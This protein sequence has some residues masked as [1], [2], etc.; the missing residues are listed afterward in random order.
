MIHLITWLPLPYQR[1]LCQTL[2]DYYEGAFRAWFAARE[3]EDFPFRPVQQAE[4]TEYYLSEVGYQKLFRELRADREAV[5]ILGGWSSP[6]ANKTLLITTL[7]GIPVFIWA[8]HPH[9]RQRTRIADQLR[10]SYLRLLSRVVS[11]FLACGD[12]TVRHLVSLGIARKKI[13]GFSYWVKIP[14]EWSVPKRCSDQ[15][16]HARP[17]RLVAV[18]RHILVKQFGVAIHAV[19]LANKN[20]GHDL[21]ELV[22]IGDG[23]ER[24]SLEVVAHS[25]NGEASIS[26]TGWLEADEVLNEIR[27]ADALVLTSSFDAFG[28]VVLEAMAAGRPVLAS[29][30]V[31][32]AN[33]RDEKTGAILSHPIGDFECLAEQITSLANDTERLRVASTS[34]RATAEKWPPERAVLIMEEILCARKRG[35]LLLERGRKKGRTRSQD[36]RMRVKIDEEQEA[37][38]G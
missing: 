28:V 22:L 34:A 24:R 26:F 18:G 2:N 4:F 10:R 37:S 14:R 9:P 8:D 36:R 29:A 11:G 12:P 27:K 1:T 21:A 20:A 38:K 16:A 13:M 5:V 6:M 30:G 7:L 25:Y 23:P 31:V 3:H 32:A 33:D 17:L 19:A 35:R 15:I